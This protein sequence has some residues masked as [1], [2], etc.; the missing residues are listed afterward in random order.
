MDDFWKDENALLP[1]AGTT[2]AA[3][4]VEAI[5]LLKEAG[6]S[7]EKE[8]ASGGNGSTLLA[9]DGVALP[10]FIL[11]APQQDRL[12]EMAAKHIA[13]QGKVLGLTITVE[14]RNSDDLLYAV[15]G[16]GNYDMALLGWRLSAYP[17]Y[18]CDWFMPSGQ[19][20]FAYSGS[21]HGAAC[22]AWA[23]VNDLDMAKTH[24]FEV[25]SALMQDLPLIPLYANVRVDAYRN[26]RYPF[27]EV[28]DG[29]GWLY[30]APAL[31]IPVP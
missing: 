22:E 11:L 24:A 17:A 18:L 3:R 6:Y 20:P 5:R 1:C 13:Q 4:L 8:P 9:P 26:V 31:A 29:L 10:S 21:S 23:Q 2:G 12:R 14:L 16:S 28:I 7:W 30:G 25:Q 15:Y 27:A 19:N